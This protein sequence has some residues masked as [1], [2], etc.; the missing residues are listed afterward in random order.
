MNGFEKAVED[1]GKVVAWPFVHAA[2]VVEVLTTALED[3]PTVKTA[4]VGLVQQIETVTAD[5]AIAISADGINLPDDLA[6][7]A[8]A[9]TLFAYVKNVFLP[10][11]EKAYKDLDSAVTETP[12]PVAS[13]DATESASAPVLSPGPGLHT[14]T[15]A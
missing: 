7:V 6:E 11:V 15:A 12:A 3:E 5:G 13:S 9:Q 10:A 14:I 4:I 1:V 2:K 8:A